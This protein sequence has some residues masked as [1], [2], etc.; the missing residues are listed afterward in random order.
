MH[1]SYYLGTKLIVSYTWVILYNTNRDWL[2]GLELWHFQGWLSISTQG[3]LFFQTQFSKEYWVQTQFSKEYWAPRI[4]A[5]K[6]VNHTI[7]SLSYPG[8]RVFRAVW[9]EI[10]RGSRR[11]FPRFPHVK[12]QRER[13]ITLSVWL[14]GCQS[15]VQLYPNLFHIWNYCR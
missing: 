4:N 3:D 9:T 2:L 6:P 10:S 13:T 15:S 14:A 1:G 5:H 8:T 12:Q 7:P 11:K